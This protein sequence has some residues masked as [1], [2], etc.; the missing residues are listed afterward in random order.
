MRRARLSGG[1]VNETWRVERAGRRFA[2]RRAR[3]GR[4]ATRLDADWERRVVGAAAVAGLAPA[5]EHAEPERGILLLRWV[6]GRHWSAAE[7]ASPG[8]LELL[9]QVIRRLQSLAVPEPAPRAGPAEWIAH[10]REAF[11]ARGGCADPRLNEACAAAAVRVRQGVLQG[12]H[13]APALLC[14]GDLHPQNLLVEHAQVTLL[15][16]EYAHVA[17]PYWDLAGWITHSDLPEVCARR[18]LAAYLGREAR[19]T[20]WSQLRLLAWAYD[21]V[22]VLW[23]AL[24][25]DALQAAAAAIAVAQAHRRAAR[26]A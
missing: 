20:E 8:N 19:A 23:S 6:A 2:L 4:G 21:Y 26:L 18:L 14:H 11:E 1:L 16:W 17:H 15:D 3:P 22:C 9:A 10:Y 5:I 25:L 13:E 24:C 7:A 12:L